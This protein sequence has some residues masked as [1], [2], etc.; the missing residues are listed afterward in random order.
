MFCVEGSAKL[1]VVNCNHTSDLASSVLGCISRWDYIETLDLSH[2]KLGSEPK[3]F[4]DWLYHSII[5]AV[6]IETIIISDNDFSEEWKNKIFS[7]FK[8]YCTI[9]L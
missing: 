8:N 7:Y 5:G 2:N 1:G 9:I 6:L 3:Q 4:Y